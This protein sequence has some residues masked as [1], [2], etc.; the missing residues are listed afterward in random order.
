MD[1]VPDN[2]PNSIKIYLDDERPCPPGW[3]LCTTFWQ[4]KEMLERDKEFLD[5]VSHISLDW[6][7]GH[8]DQVT[9]HEAVGVLGQMIFNGDCDNQPYMPNLK[10]VSFHSSDLDQAKKMRRS[11]EEIL[12]FSH[13]DN[14]RLRIGT[15]SL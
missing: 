7:L 12:E 1:E 6:Y 15:P 3:T 14:I 13:R 10:V 9:G 4:F 8:R 5:Q 2:S 11:L